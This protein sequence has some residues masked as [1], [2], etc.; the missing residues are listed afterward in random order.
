M[1]RGQNTLCAVGILEGESTA[2][3]DASVERVWELI[4]D[5]EHGPEWQAGLTSLVSLER[6]EQGRT[7]L[8]ETETDAKLR[9]IR[10]QVRFEYDAPTRLTWKQ[11]KGELK[12]LSGMWELTDL[13]SGRTAARYW[14]G[15]D[16]GRLGLL[17]RGPIVDVLRAQLAGR[18]ANELKAK[19]EGHR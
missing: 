11:T 2:E 1:D 18:R 15:T 7:T 16:L 4:A 19:I 6:D 8:A 3:I 14:A 5:V 12:S 10:I 9:T 13:G 17:V